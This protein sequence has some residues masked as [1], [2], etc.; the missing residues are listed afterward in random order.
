MWK[1]TLLLVAAAAAVV[2]VAKKVRDARDERELWQEAIAE[3]DAT[4]QLP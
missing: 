4:P 1:R 2:V 3:P